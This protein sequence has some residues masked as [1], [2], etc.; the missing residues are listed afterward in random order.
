MGLGFVSLTVVR[1]QSSLRAGPSWTD[2]ANIMSWLESQDCPEVNGLPSLG[3]LGSDGGVLRDLVIQNDRCRPIPRGRQIQ[4][5][6][7][8]QAETGMEGG[9]FRWLV[10]LL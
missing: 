10:H 5:E 1:T 3:L 7:P 4:G 8:R 9:P 6:T 2:R